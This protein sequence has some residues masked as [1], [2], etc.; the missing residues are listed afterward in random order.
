MGGDPEEAQSVATLLARELQ[1]INVGLE[2][3]AAELAENGVTV[4]QVDWTPPAA[5]DPVLADLV[6]KLGA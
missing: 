4:V 6:A 1:V 5:G 2:S 3:F